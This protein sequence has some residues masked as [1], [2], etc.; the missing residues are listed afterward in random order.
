MH[1]AALKHADITHANWATQPQPLPVEYDIT[2]W[3]SL[4]YTLAERT[5]EHRIETYLKD[6][7]AYT[8]T[9]FARYFEWQGVCR[10]AWFFKCVSADMLQDKGVFI[11]KA[12][13]NDYVQETFPFQTIRGQVNT[14]LVKNASFYILFRFS[15]AETGELVSGGYQQIVFADLN[16]RIC[17]LPADV[18]ETVRRYEVPLLV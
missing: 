10:E 15:N 13:H 18:L 6:S 16:R 8:N 3:Q 7:N 17:R 4:P 12:A 5:Y 9:Y 14:A 11:T 1:N 2:D